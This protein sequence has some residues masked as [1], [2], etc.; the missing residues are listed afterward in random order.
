MI[1]IVGAGSTTGA[2]LIPMLLEETD[3][4]L[5]LISSR[6]LEYDHDRVQMHIVNVRDKNALK[7]SIM[8]AMPN[9]IINLAAMTN[10]DRCE[11]ERQMAWDLNVTLVENLSRISRVLDAK[12]VHISTDYVFD[13]TKGP[14]TET[15]VPNPINYYG[16]SKLAGENICVSGNTNSLIIRTNVIYGPPRE[17][18]DFV[19]WVLDALDADTPIRVVDDQ[20][21][22]PTYV[23]DL[24]E[25][26]MRLGMSRRTGIY[27]VGGSD[28]LSRYDFAL[29]VAEFFK[30]DPGVIRRVST[31]ELAQTAK[32]PL[33]LGLVSL[34][35]ETDLR[36][37]MRGVESGL[38]SIRQYLVR[39]R[40]SL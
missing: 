15:A 28:F 5:Q 3:V 27:H 2:A 18:P 23:D 35:A 31:S 25:A 39:N 32:R 8:S 22:N 14:Y 40:D 38:T 20:I 10:V 16:K 30:L 24:A 17:R 1:T 7:Q 37:K 29:K 33:K 4:Q 19:R 12:M 13:G 11:T 36:M 26:I 6:P 21:G 9:V 34:K